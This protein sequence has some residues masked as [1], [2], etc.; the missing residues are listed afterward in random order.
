MF[1]V[2]PG[3]NLIA[4][5]IC[6]CLLIGRR[7]FLT[8]VATSKCNVPSIKN[9]IDIRR[10]VFNAM[11]RNNCTILDMQSGNETLEEAFLK[12]VTQDQTQKSTGGRK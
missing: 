2:F 11:A 9:G 3:L 1:R 5:S 7:Q 10:E 6:S 12:L 8:L 4:I